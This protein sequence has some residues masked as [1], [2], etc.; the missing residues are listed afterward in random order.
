MPPWVLGL[1]SLT[2]VVLGGGAAGYGGGAQASKDIADIEVKMDQLVKQIND[3]EKSIIRYHA[4][5]DARRNNPGG[6]R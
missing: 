5:D 1:L 2:G 3:L 4:L 6:P